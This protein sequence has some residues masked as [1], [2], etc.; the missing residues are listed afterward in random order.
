[1]LIKNYTYGMVKTPKVTKSLFVFLVSFPLLVLTGCGTSAEDE[2]AAKV[3]AQIN[4]ACE[5]YKSG[6][7]DTKT[8]KE[9]AKLDISYME[10]SVAAQE[11]YDLALSLALISEG[12]PYEELLQEINN[13]NVQ[14]GLSA[15]TPEQYTA[16]NQ[17]TVWEKGTEA[18]KKL[19]ILCTD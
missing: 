8:F 17:P 15:L 3:K 18:K 13:L 1:M 19:N 10:I 2:V 5:T 12:G 4:L 14:G 6:D 16:Q 9:L 7:I 11:Y